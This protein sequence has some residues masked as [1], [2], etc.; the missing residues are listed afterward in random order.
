M[1]AAIFSATRR[2]LG[3]KGRRELR[4]KGMNIERKRL[5]RTQG[6]TKSKKKRKKS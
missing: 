6:L 4:Q 2:E 3:P 5:K 1:G